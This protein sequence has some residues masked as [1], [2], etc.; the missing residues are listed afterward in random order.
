MT[1]RGTHPAIPPKP[2]LKNNAK[3]RILIVDDQVSFTW[4]LKMNLEVAD[5]Y[6][7]T[8]VNDPIKGLALAIKIA[9]DI[10]ITDVEMPGMFG[11]ELAAKIHEIPELKDLPIIF[12][13]ATQSQETLKMLE[14]HIAKGHV[15]SKPVNVDGIIEFIE[16]RLAE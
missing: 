15:F 2:H 16:K 1:A 3:K 7:V 12:L 11:H 14:P 8:V 5:E 13:T 4:L 6:E 9:P 10:V